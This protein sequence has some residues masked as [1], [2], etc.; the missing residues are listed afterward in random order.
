MEFRILGPL[1]VVDGEAPLAVGGPKPRALLAALLLRPGAVVS[2]DRLTT[3]VW[4]A[5][6]PRDALGALRAY[7]SRLRVAMPGERLR[8]R[9]PGYRLDVAEG[10]LDAAAFTRLL[11]QARERA[12]LADTAGAV[13]LFDAALG[14]WRG[15]ALAEFDAADIDADGHLARL[16][17]LRLAAAQERAEALL[18]LG[19][20]REVVVELEGLVDRHP[21]REALSALLMRALYASD[22]QTDALA[23]Y[24][25]LRHR[26]VEE[27][28]VEPSDATREVHRKV[29]EQDP[30]LAPVDRAPPANL[31]RR[32]T[33]LVGR[34]RAIVDVAAALRAAPLV[35]LVGM[36]GVGKTRLAGEVARRELHRFREGAWLCELA[37][38]TD[39]G[40]VAHAVA[41]ALRLQQRHGAT[42][43]ETVV[44]YLANRSLL[45]VLDNC[46]HVLDAAARLAVSVVAHC[47]GVVV[48]ATS[49]EP[50][51]VAGEQVWP[52]PPL[53]LQ[54]ATTL[55]VQR[56]RATRP[57]FDPDSEPSGSVAEVC[58]RLDGLPLGIELAAARTRAMSVT[59]IAGRLDDRHLLANGPRTAEPRHQSLAAAIEW[60][61]RLL[62]KPEQLLFARMSVFA[63]GADLAAVHAVCA[64]PGMTEAESLDL[65]AALVDKSMVEAVG[66]DGRT[67]YRVLETLRAYGR[68]RLAEGE[69]IGR[70]HAE[71]FVGLAEEAARGVQGVD[72]CT[73][74]DATLPDADNLRAASVFALA[75]RD[76]DLAV[77]LAAA[78]PEVLSVRRGFEAAEWAESALDLTDARHPLFARAVGAAA[79]GA[80]CVGDFAKA[81]TLAARAEGLDPGIGTARSGYP[82]DVAADVALYQGDVG[83]AEAYYGAQV[84]RARE[85]GDRIRLVWTLYYVAIC[86]AV[87]RVPERGV[88]AARESLEVATA[89]GNP[90]ALSMARY[91]LG[92][93]LKKAE[94]RRALTLLDEAARLAASVHNFWWE[95]IALMEA[96]ATRAVHGD[97][98]EA[99]HALVAVLDHWDRVGDWT[100]QWLNLRYVVRLLVRLGAEQDAATLHHCLLAAGKPSPLDPAAAAQLLDGPNGVRFGAAARRG[101]ELSAAAAVA[102]ARDSL[103]RSP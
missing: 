80:W 17:D 13:E 94:P 68:E 83:A 35:T 36:G 12:A 96:A 71:Y 45:L 52:V 29:L 65:V 27:L 3:A 56:A 86:H 60:S 81:G 9:A 54:D 72:E 79:R 1:E 21:D 67:R 97:A 6:P 64:E 31:P 4:G 19:R 101:A 73:W 84:I 38:L 34:D 8:W 42:I 90:T 14:L 46:E 88:A 62:E 23:V 103:S 28:G 93:V 87:Q 32:G 2:T 98:A 41:V 37:P 69:P 49:R 59:E 40:A 61:Y 95:G 75:E 39:G 50:L 78:L 91:A 48:L 25:T 66:R 92:L 26:L 5:H 76:A 89:T 70:R 11:G 55:F 99:A 102:L 43:E 57:D 51:G 85:E 24:R 33:G 22:R 44:E 77:R 74:V 82:D 58:L 7:V 100:Q 47:P 20:G 18:A 53:P 15:D 63:G 10:E 16:A 30:A